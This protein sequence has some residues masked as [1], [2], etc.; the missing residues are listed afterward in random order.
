MAK[1]IA[2]LLVIHLL[3]GCWSIGFSADRPDPL[4]DEPM[5]ELLGKPRDEVRRSLKSEI[6]TLRS[7]AIAYSNCDVITA[8]GLGCGAVVFGYVPVPMCHKNSAQFCVVLRYDKEGRLA[9]YE[10]K[11]QSINATL[12]DVGPSVL[13]AASCEAQLSLAGCGPIV[14]TNQ[15]AGSE[16]LEAPSPIEEGLTPCPDGFS[17]EWLV[18]GRVLCHP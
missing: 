2:Y 15:H 9:S 3:A 10:V 18:D 6:E 8:L 17:E 16:L 1:S 4:E 5:T 13:E 7:S 14:S 12:G 11:S